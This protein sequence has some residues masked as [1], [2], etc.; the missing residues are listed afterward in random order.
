MR[1]ALAD[2]FR[3]VS[4]RRSGQ[5]RGKRRRS[6]K[7][8][9][10]SILDICWVLPVLIILGLSGYFIRNNLEHRIEDT[11]A[12][13]ADNALVLCGDRLDS[14]LAACR[15]IN[16]DGT[17]RRAWSDYLA[18][19]NGVRLYETVNGYLSQKYSYDENF[20][21]VMLYYTR[22]PDRIYFVSNHAS[23]DRTSALHRYLSNAHADVQTLSE[24]LDT[25]ALFFERDG[26]IYLMRNIVDSSF[27]PYAVVIME[28]SEEMLFASVG[29]IVWLTD[30]SIALDGIT[31]T[32]AGAG[33][34]PGEWSAVGYHAE[35][36]AYYVYRNLS[37]DDYT[38]SLAARADATT[39]TEELTGFKE[40][41]PLIV[42]LAIPLLLLVF[43]AFSRYV[44]RPLNALVEASAHVA[45]GERGYTVSP[46]PNSREFAS[47]AESFNSMSLELRAQFERSYEEQLTLQDARIKA[48]QSQINPHFL[49]NTLEIINWEARME[50]NVRVTR[51]IEA[52]S[53][54]LEAA[55]ARGGSSVVT[56]AE[57]L[58]YVDAY[59]YI[60]SERYN[61]RLRVEKRFDP[62]LLGREVPRL[63]L[64]PIVENA[65]AHGIERGAK[66][67]LTISAERSGD[68]MLLQVENDGAMT[69]A[70]RETIARL[71]EW[72][73]ESVP[74]D[75][76]PAS[77]I[78]IRNVNRR[79]KL[80]CGARGGLTISETEDGRVRA[81]IVIPLLRSDA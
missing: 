57:E 11:L 73:G 13:S 26:T 47:L 5:A 9:L 14:A 43:L 36:R 74:E 42:A 15:G 60:L 39:I 76:L 80:L 22:H 75:R 20:K 78:G 65:I 3:A 31:Y 56:L 8:G 30:A 71:L 25:R 28:C 32:V 49:N 12:T 81:C 19:A 41:M 16:Y 79:L 23:S 77:H 2:I 70:D 44:T 10:L 68:D 6:L 58:R 38:L 37:T 69:D 59:L 34:E 52:L 4:G 7:L 35:E 66:G 21:S 18:N 45:A 50:G 48:L 62:A 24:T 46:L 33:V 64:Q 29:S 55:T 61:G 72:D 51:M 67:E 63:V 54:M 53:T 1:G 17:V 27:D 40:I